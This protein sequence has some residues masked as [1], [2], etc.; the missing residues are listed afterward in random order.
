M[1]CSGAKCDFDA[2]EISLASESPWFF[3]AVKFVR[4][5]ITLPRFE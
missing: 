4:E 1:T 2:C 3:P 5:K